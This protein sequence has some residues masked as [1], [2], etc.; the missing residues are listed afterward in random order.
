MWLCGIGTVVSRPPRGANKIS[1]S[2]VPTCTYRPTRC[3]YW[4]EGGLKAKRKA[5]MEAQGQKVEANDCA[6][7]V[8]NDGAR[9]FGAP[10]SNGFLLSGDST[11]MMDTMRPLG[12]SN[13][14]GITFPT[15]SLRRSKQSLLLTRLRRQLGL[16]LW[17]LHKRFMGLTVT[18]SFLVAHWHLWSCIGVK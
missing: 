1:P 9:M 16:I 7:R 4:G 5:A 12:R 13:A 2:Y 8:R 18:A 15:G 11:M 10:W 6:S 17:R 14:T 3:V